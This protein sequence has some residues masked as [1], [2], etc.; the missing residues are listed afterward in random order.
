MTKI[1]ILLNKMFAFYDIM[2]EI[3]KIDGAGGDRFHCSTSRAQ[4]I[5]APAGA[6]CLLQVQ[7]PNIDSLSAADD[8][9]RPTIDS[10]NCFH[11]KKWP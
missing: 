9:P 4:G 6:M 2:L 7:L 11:P 5:T 3:D 10:L 1:G 8:S